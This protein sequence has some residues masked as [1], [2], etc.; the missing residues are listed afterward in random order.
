MCPPEGTY[1][2]RAEVGYAGQVYHLLTE[3]IIFIKEEK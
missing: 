2:M 3:D 1:I